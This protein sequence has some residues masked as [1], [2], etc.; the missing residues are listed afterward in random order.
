MKRISTT[1]AIVALGFATAASL[2]AQAQN[3]NTVVTSEVCDTAFSQIDQMGQMMD[4][5]HDSISVTEATSWGFPQGAF[6][7]LDRNNDRSISRTEFSNC[8]AVQD[9]L[10]AGGWD[11]IVFT[12]GNDA[13]I[14]SMQA[15]Q[16]AR[17]AAERAE[18]AA[19]SAQ[20]AAT[21]MERMERGIQRK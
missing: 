15:A 6:D 13:T 14:R 20:A 11:I 1:A 4:A 7:K 21:R 2:P 10:R 19:Q 17:A 18:Q 12:S 5:D 16:A 8:A 3:Q 9:D